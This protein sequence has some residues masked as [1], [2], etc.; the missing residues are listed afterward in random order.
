[1]AVDRGVQGCWLAARHPWIQRRPLIG[2]D[3]PLDAQ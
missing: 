2:P 1:M 3:G